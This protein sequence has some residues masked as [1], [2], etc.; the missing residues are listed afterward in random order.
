MNGIALLPGRRGYAVPPGF[1]T[2]FS[3]LFAPLAD[4]MRPLHWYADRYDSSPFNGMTGERGNEGWYDA[5]VITLPDQKRDG[6]S[7]SG[8]LF[9]PGGL[10]GAGRHLNQDWMDLVGIPGDEASAV[11]VAQRLYGNKDG[12]KAYHRFIG[13]QADLY[14]HC[15]D[16]WSWELYAADDGHLRRAAEH[17]SA[18]PSITVEPTTLDAKAQ[19]P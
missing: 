11:Q 4:A 19:R 3:Y 17:L 12:N 5:A 6:F 10:P 2:V 9:R 1:P 15:M 8:L 18:N 16:G 7:R 14:F 13:E